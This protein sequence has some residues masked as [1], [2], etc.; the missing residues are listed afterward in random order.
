MNFCNIK[1]LCLLSF[2]LRK[3]FLLIIRIIKIVRLIVYKSWI[4]LTITLIHSTVVVCMKAESLL[5]PWLSSSSWIRWTVLWMIIRVFRMV[6]LI[7]YKSWIRFTIILIHSTVVVSMKA[8]SLLIPW[9]SSSSWIRWT[10]INF[11]NKKILLW[12]IIMMNLWALFL[13]N[14][15]CIGPIHLSTLIIMGMI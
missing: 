10:G 1:I 7:V 13:Y 5:I 8:E 6:R 15:F 12:M 4:R 9:L 2:G 3:L 11:L 14:L